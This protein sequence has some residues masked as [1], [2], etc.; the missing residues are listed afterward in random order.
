MLQALEAHLLTAVDAA[1]PAEV[2]TVA[3]PWQPTGTGAVVVHARTLTL[4]PPGEDPP[5]DDAAH[6]LAIVD[7]PS[8]GNTLDFEIPNDQTGELLEVE[9]PPGFTVRRGDAW[10]LD[11]RTIRFYMAP[12]SG[13]PGVRARLRG[14]PAKGYKRRKP[15]RVELSI[16]A[17]A[18]SMATADQRLDAALQT[19]LK[20]LIQLPNLEAGAVAG[21]Q[22][23]MR[24]LQARAWLLSIERRV[25]PESDLFEARA[26]L[27]L[28]GDLDLLVAVGTPDPVGVIEKLAGAM[29]I[30]RA[31]GQPMLPEAF[32]VTG[33]SNE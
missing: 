7:W 28:R 33:Q 9:S 16:S 1:L 17:W 5:T 23:W 3:G 8:D 10:Q 20:E 32:E 24:I 13:A 15:C 21:V 27:E 29:K 4:K 31:N 25:D 12:A 18:D 14:A 2:T 11:D 19:T 6:G 26:T 30:N 22:V